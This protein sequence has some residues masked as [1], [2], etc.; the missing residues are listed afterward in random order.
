MGLLRDGKGKK[1]ECNEHLWIIG[2][3]GNNKVAVGVVYMGREGLVE[4]WNDQ[5]I[6]C[7]ED[8]IGYWQR[9]DREVV[10]I[11]DFNAHVERLHGSTNKNGK[12]LDVF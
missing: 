4:S 2:T 12:K 5:I 11:G 9:M 1:P 8:D 3:L 7:L 6:S 10:L